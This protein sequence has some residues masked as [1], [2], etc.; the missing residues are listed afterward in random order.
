MGFGGQHI[1]LAMLDASIHFLWPEAMWNETYLD[2]KTDMPNLSSIY[3]LFPATDGWVMVYPVATDAHWQG[4]CEALSRPDLAVDPRFADLQGRVL[5]GGDVNDELARET[6]RFSSGELVA[7]MDAAD[8]PVGPVNTRQEVIAD[9]HVQHRGIVVES[10]HP[11]CW[12][13]P[14]CTSA[15]S[16][17]GDSVSAGAAC[18]PARRAHRRGAR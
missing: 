3:A 18:T 7:L 4:M 2:H 12:T 14:H 8:V 1:E 17:L 5:Y 10:V 11:D 6:A 16:F 9:P 13:H 15:R